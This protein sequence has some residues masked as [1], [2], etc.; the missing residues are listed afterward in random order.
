MLRSATVDEDDGWSTDFSLSDE[1]M[2]ET[3]LDHV[4]VSFLPPS[5]KCDDN[6]RGVYFRNCTRSHC[7]AVT[8]CWP[9]TPLWDRPRPASGKEISSIL[10][11]WDAPDG[12]TS[13][14]HQVSTFLHF[15]SKPQLHIFNFQFKWAT[16]RRKKDGRRRR[17][18][19]RP[20][21]RPS[22]HL[23]APVLLRHRSAVKTA[24]T[25]IY[26][27]RGKSQMEMKTIGSPAV[28]SVQIGQ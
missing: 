24:N 3:Y 10:F 19:R 6:S 17:I 26:N 15:I 28:A 11:A 23:A 21:H 18:W 27:K 2:G 22:N 13:A 1:D 7:D 14:R 12:G 20:Q 25:I 4:E 5:V 16:P 8:S 9:T